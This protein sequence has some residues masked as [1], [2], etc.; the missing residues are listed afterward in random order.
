MTYQAILAR[1]DHTLLA[2]TA[3]WEEI[4]RLCE[5]AVFYHTASVCIPPCFVKKAKDYLGNQ[6]KVCTVIGFPNGNHTMRSKMFEAEDALHHGADELDM[7]S[8]IG[9]LKEKKDDD[10]EKEIRA[11]KETAGNHVLKVIIETCLLD[12]EEKIRMWEIGT[13][14]VAD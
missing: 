4:R 2:Q 7:V 9:A 11:L 10:V 14:A 5:D 1:V 6:M 8:N 13:N 3:T 12:R